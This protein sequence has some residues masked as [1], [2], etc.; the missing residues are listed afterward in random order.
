MNAEIPRH[1]ARLAANAACE[2]DDLVRDIP[3]DLHNT[4]A[5]VP[6]LM[7]LVERTNPQNA[8][9]YD[10]S[11]ITLMSHFLEESGWPTKV[12]TVDDLI[13][14]TV[15]LCKQLESMWAPEPSQKL[16]AELRRL[17]VELSK[18]AMAR[19]EPYRRVCF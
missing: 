8:I 12:I 2:L 3:S 16:A 6:V 4:K 13:R 9:S 17:S 1:L 14:E 11:G 18:H 15:L 19:I 7:T 10:P 5:L